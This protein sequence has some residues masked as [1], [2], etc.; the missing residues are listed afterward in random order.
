MFVT[1]DPLGNPV[2]R[3][4]P[5]NQHTI[6]QPQKRDFDDKYSWVMSPRWFDGTSHLAADTGGGPLPRLWATALGGLVDIGYV[7]STGH[8]VEIN[9][10]RTMSKPAVRKPEA[11]RIALSKA[12][13]T[14]SRLL[15]CCIFSLRTEVFIPYAAANSALSPHWF[16]TS[17][18]GGRLPAGKSG[19]AIGS[20]RLDP[21][22]V[23]IGIG[24]PDVLP[25]NTQRTQTG[26]RRGTAR[27]RR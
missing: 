24:D 4:H 17:R 12:P 19:Q 14:R 13:G 21:L 5:W 1:K 15:K 26:R 8:S 22:A 10:P 7:R 3:N 6:P 11:R 27:G 16:R 9:L 20:V 23:I 2:D 18:L 25:R